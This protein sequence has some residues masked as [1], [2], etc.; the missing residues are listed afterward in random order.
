LRWWR[1]ESVAGGK[2][3]V[4]AHLYGAIVGA[5]IAPPI[6]LLQRYQAIHKH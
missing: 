3:L 5:L 2:V 6:L 1:R 4:D